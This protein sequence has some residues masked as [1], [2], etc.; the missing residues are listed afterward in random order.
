M[1]EYK[2]P[3]IRKIV[4]DIWLPPPCQSDGSVH[5]RPEWPLPLG[6]VLSPCSLSNKVD[7]LLWCRQIVFGRFQ[8]VFLRAVPPTLLSGT[9]E[10]DVLTGPR[11]GSLTL[12]EASSTLSIYLRVLYICLLM[13]WLTAS[14]AFLWTGWCYRDSVCLWTQYVKTLWTNFNDILGNV[15]NGPRKKNFIFLFGDVL[16]WDLSSKYNFPKPRGIDHN[17]NHCNVISYH[18]CL[19]TFYFKYKLG[20]KQFD[21]KCILSIRGNLILKI[22]ELIIR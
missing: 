8:T 15:D 4:K 1:P 2:K 13:A 7:Q 18:L 22:Y 20:A 14:S 16:E 6:N 11:W 3:G 21:W 17:P 19:I 10:D 9:G 12:L 5:S